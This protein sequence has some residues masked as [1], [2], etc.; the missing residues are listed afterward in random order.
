MPPPGSS[1]HE[2]H[3]VLL[4]ALHKENVRAPGRRKD[5]IGN[6]EPGELATYAISTQA[7]GRE[8]VASG[9]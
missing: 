2:S 1:S 8:I 5:H 9:S 7:N 4:E 6:P 3:K